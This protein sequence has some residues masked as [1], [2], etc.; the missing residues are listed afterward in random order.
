[1]RTFSSTSFPTLL[2]QPLP[3]IHQRPPQKILPPPIPIPLRILLR[4]P[5]APNPIMRTRLHQL[6]L[7]SSQQHASQILRILANRK[8]VII[9]LCYNLQ[10]SYHPVSI[11]S[12]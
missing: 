12:F 4:K 7:S 1:M 6:P 5:H 9:A 11:P 3:H 8:L 2:P 10:L